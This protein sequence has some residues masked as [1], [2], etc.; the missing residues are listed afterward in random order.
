M[1]AWSKPAAAQQ[2]Y[3]VVSTGGLSSV[4]NLCSLLGCQVQGS[5]D[6]KLGQTFLVTSTNLLNTTLT[7]LESLLGIVSIERDLFLPIARPS[8]PSIPYGLY[9]TS[10]VNYYGTVVWHGYAAQPAAQI[11][12]IQ[13]AQNRSEER[14]VGKECRSRWSPYH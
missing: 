7:L 3:I 6:G 14:R 4:L 2:R 12:R 9:D 8:L 10:P 5:L 1:L 13:D 11:I